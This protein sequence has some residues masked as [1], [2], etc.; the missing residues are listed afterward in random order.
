[1]L[2]A[3]RDF[4]LIT[5]GFCMRAADIMN[6]SLG[7]LCFARLPGPV[8]SYLPDT[9]FSLTV[10]CSK[11]NKDGEKD[12]RQ[13]ARHKD[14]CRCPIAALARVLFKQ[15]IGL[16]R[17][18]KVSIQAL[19]DG[20]AA[21]IFLFKGAHVLDVTY[22]ALMPEQVERGSA[23]RSTAL[24]RADTEEASSVANEQISQQVQNIFT[25]F[26]PWK[27][28]TKRLHAGRQTATSEMAVAEYVLIQRSR[29]STMMPCDVRKVNKCQLNT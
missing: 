19:V 29:C 27:V 14:P 13:A 28:L 5:C 23:L 17:N 24:C 22:K 21:R 26:L 20:L 15:V 11:T 25:E 16:V 6:A 1:L 10:P 2:A 12:E 18:R 8:Q 9:A 7:H 3:R 4:V